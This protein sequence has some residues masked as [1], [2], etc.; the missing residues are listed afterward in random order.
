M[1]DSLQ[2]LKHNQFWVNPDSGLKTRKE[3]E[4]VAALAHMV[5]AGKNPSSAGTTSCIVIKNLT[6]LRG[7][8]F[9]FTKLFICPH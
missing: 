6:S 7:Q 3:P 2:V 8:V 4:T 1:Q 9:S 5:A